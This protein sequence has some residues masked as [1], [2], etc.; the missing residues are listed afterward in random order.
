MTVATHRNTSSLFQ[1]RPA[2]PS[3]LRI[4]AQMIAE[5]FH[6]QNG[7]WGIFFPL[8]RLGI[9]ED[10]KHRFASP[11]PHH[12][13]LVAVDTQAKTLQN[14]VGTVELNLRFSDPWMLPKKTFPYLSNLAVHPLYRRKGVASSLLKSC[15]KVSMAW[16]FEDIYLHV[17][18]NNCK[19]RQLYFKSGYRVQ[20]LEFNWNNFLLRRSQQIFLHKNIRITNRSI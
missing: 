9:Y 18:E 10:L 16:G 19:A 6:S 2:S 5:S 3:D 7:W 8:L 15:E 13:C 4:V 12:I 11:S 14:I 20:N 17:L 1:V